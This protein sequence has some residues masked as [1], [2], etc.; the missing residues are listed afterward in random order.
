MG[1]EQIL[2]D[3]QRKNRFKELVYLGDQRKSNSLNIPRIYVLVRSDL[4]PPLHQGIQAAHACLL[5]A[6]K[7]AVDPNSYLIL[8]SATETDIIETVKVIGQKNAAMYFDT[9][10]IHPET[11]MPVCTAVAFKPM[12][13]K[14]GSKIFDKFKRSQ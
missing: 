2:N 8:L 7:M 1:V 10:L 12:S 6:S 13:L 3:W 14:D 11:S 9:G 5:L 4:L